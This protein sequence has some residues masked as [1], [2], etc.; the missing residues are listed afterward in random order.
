MV[1][2]RYISL[3][4]TVDV[5]QFLLYSLQKC[6]QIESISLWQNRWQSNDR[7]QVHSELIV[8]SEIRALY[9]KNYEI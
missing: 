5:F 7:D 4:P 8:D 2:S 1:G 3:F 6:G 9:Y